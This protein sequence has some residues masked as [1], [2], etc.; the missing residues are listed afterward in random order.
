MRRRIPSR[1]PA[2]GLVAVTVAVTQV[3]L[4]TN[5]AAATL[6]DNMVPTQHYSARCIDDTASSNGPVC[7]TD[8]ATLTVYRQGSLTASEQSII[9]STL[10]ADYNNP[11]NLNVSYETS[12]TVSYSGSAET[13]IIYQK[14]PYQSGTTGWGSGLIGETW[15]DNAVNALACDQQYVRFKSSIVLDYP[16][17][18]H[19]TGHA[20]GLLHGADSDSSTGA[21]LS[22]TDPALGCMVTPVNASITTLSSKEI[23][24]INASY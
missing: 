22:N 3:I 21:T 16:I 10:N 2:F 11:T 12:G 20:V 18:C 17:V 8:N 14:S 7:Q 4:S 23:S 24:E 15:C 9:L 6:A 1:V 5:A 13:D 19:E